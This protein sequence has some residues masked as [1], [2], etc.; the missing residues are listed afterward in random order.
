MTIQNSGIYSFTDINVGLDYKGGNLSEAEI[1]LYADTVPGNFL[2]D[3]IK[4]Y[5]IISTYPTDAILMAD[6][7]FHINKSDLYKDDKNSRQK[8]EIFHWAGAKWEMCPSVT[9]SIEQDKTIVTCNNITNISSPWVLAYG[10]ERPNINAGIAG[11]G[12]LFI[13]WIIA[14]FLSPMKK[15][16]HE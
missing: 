8:I 5:Y 3:P 9:S 15:K 1:C 7:S 10:I 11:L 14:F 2:G 12:G 6:L 16:P 13:M 4:Q